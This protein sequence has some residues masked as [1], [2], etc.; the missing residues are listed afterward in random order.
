MYVVAFSSTT[1]NK[2]KTSHQVLFMCALKVWGLI[3]A[4]SV[5]IVALY[6]KI[7]KLLI[8]I[9]YLKQP[10]TIKNIR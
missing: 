3:K 6:E 8:A 5:T 2:Q 9:G 1:K 10:F 4:V 7:T